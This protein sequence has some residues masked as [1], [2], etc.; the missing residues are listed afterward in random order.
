MNSDKFFPSRIIY[1]LLTLLIAMV[2]DSPFIML[3]KDLNEGLSQTL[4][5]ALFCT[6]FII[7]VA[8]INVK[9]RNN[10]LP[11]YTKKLDSLWLAM[12]IVFVIQTLI[13]QP[14]ITLLNEKATTNTYDSCTIIGS[15]IFA[16]ILEETIFRGIL[17]RGLL[18]RY[19]TPIAITLSTLL[20]ALIHINMN[21]IIPAFLL[22]I[23]FGLVF[24]KTHSFIFTAILHF[25]ANA[26]T[27][28]FVFSNSEKIYQALDYRILL[29]IL[30]L[31]IP[32]Y[33]YGCITI[34]KKLRR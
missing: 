33:C 29:A 24:A 30:I 5:F 9:K 3:I 28:L 6:T 32:L 27:W 22:G 31:S 20:F 4:F 14:A 26:I 34:S 25:E 2:I 15:L 23:L 11:Y 8:A 18:T 12:L 21:Q 19:S 7:V 10:V 16:P 13:S 1:F 17:L